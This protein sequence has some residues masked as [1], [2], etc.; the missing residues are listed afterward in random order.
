VDL[1]LVHFPIGNQ[2]APRRLPSGDIAKDRDG[3]DIMDTVAEYDFMHMWRRLE[4]LVRA[5]KTR[6]IGISNFNVTQ[7]DELLRRA[8]IQPYTH[9]IESHPYLQDWAFYDFHRERGLHLT[10]YAPLGNTNPDYHYRNWKSAGRLMINDPVLKR[11]ASE[12]GDCTPAQI[13]LAW[14]LARNVTVIP[15]AFNPIHQVENYEAHEK[16]KITPQDADRIKRLDDNG[17]G[18]KRYWD[19]CCMMMLPC[20]LGLQ[21][22]PES[23][24][25]PADFCQQEG[26]WAPSYAKYNKERNDLWLPPK[27]H[28]T[29][30]SLL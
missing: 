16:C 10:A 17:R 3:K 20:Y 28:Q 27:R 7:V 12:H 21:D 23:L 5:G 8:K 11:I 1:T 6:Y 2:A 9:Q 4:D 25:A 26:G 18:G 29:E 13:S 30:R 19:M 22:A 24:P 15:K 14:N